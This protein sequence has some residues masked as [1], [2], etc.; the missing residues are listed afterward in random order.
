MDFFSVAALLCQNGSE[1]SAVERHMECVISPRAR[2]SAAKRICAT[3]QSPGR[4]KNR[5]EKCCTAH[6]GHK[7]HTCTCF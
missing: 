7:T 5:K 6:V 1:Y 2:R 3:G 4:H